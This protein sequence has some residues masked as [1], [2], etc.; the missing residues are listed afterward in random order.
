M[1]SIASQLIMTES[2]DLLRSSIVT[3]NNSNHSIEY[4]G[5]FDGVHEK[6]NT[7]FYDGVISPPIVS[8]LAC[9]FDC[10]V[11]DKFTYIDLVACPHPFLDPA[12]T[13]IFDIRTENP[14]E[15]AHYLSGNFQLFTHLSISQLIAAFTSYPAQIHQSASSSTRLLW[16]Y[17]NLVEKRI[18]SKTKISVIDLI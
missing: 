3:Y 10:R 7:I 18:T 13:Y 4:A 16:Q 2:G 15:L 11:S 1:S 12:Q 8:L 17:L 9:G 5:I 6:A 14:V